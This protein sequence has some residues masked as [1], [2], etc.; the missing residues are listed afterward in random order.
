ML[1]PQAVRA[2]FTM[3]VDSTFIDFALALSS[4]VEE[5]G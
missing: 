5:R 4:Q 1:S 3:K 2:K